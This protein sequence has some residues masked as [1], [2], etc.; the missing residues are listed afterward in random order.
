MMEAMLCV[1]TSG[2]GSLLFLD[3]VSAGISSRVNCEAY[4]DIQPLLRFNQ[5]VD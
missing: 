1:A 5:N 2:T 3:D 4:R